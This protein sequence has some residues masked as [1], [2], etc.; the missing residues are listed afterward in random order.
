MVGLIATMILLAD[1]AAPDGGDPAGFNI[2]PVLV[3]IFVLF[4]FIDLFN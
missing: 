2:W 3:I 1:A 4:Y